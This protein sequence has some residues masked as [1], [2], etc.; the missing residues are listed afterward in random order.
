MAAIAI[1]GSG[2]VAH[3]LGGAL[4]RN[5]R[6]TIGSRNPTEAAAAWPGPDVRV[7]DLAEAACAGDVVVNALPGHV[8]V[9]VLRGL[10]PHLAGKVLLDVANA[11]RFDA[12]GF[13][14]GLVHPGGSLA[15][16]LQRALPD[17]RVVKSLNTA[18]VSVMADPASLSVPP[19]VF[20]SGDDA[21][22][23]A[24][25]AGLL[26]ELGWWQDRIIDLGPVESARGPEAFILMVGG[27]VRHLGPVPFALA[28]AC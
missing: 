7:T 21:D 20:L 23:K 18:H 1:L 5:H 3:T 8:S 24:A 2:N 17:V 19:S 9:D 10:A 25:V 13:A 16:E 27:L 15:E 28:V 22:A 26:A 12:R 4:A 6:I 14:S 11:V